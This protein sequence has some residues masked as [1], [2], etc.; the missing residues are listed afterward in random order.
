MIAKFNPTGTHIHGGFLKVRI[1]L[2]PD[3]TDKTYPI[4]HVQVPVI[5]EK[6]YQGKVDDMGSPVDQKAYD[7]WIDGLPKVWQLNPALCHFI[8]IK[9]DTTPLKLNRMVKELFDKDTLSLLDDLLSQP[10]I[11]LKGV[12]KLKTQAI[13]DKVVSA[14]IGTINTRLSSLEVQV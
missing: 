11:N 13:N 14:D 3:L 6:G 7:K 12:M 2:F 10:V 4:H 9:V 8:N 5:P 1:D